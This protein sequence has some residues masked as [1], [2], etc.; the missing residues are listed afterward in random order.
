[1]DFENSERYECD[2]KT[3]LDI[4][5]SKK[6]VRHNFVLIIRITNIIYVIVYI[7]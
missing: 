3:S 1:M 7:L 6:F 4:G 5:E 2:G